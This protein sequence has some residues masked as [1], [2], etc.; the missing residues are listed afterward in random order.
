MAEELSR[1]LRSIACVF[2]PYLTLLPEGASSPPGGVLPAC[3]TPP[4]RPFHFPKPCPIHQ[5][6]QGE[7][8]PFN[9]LN[10]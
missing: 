7:P 5:G 9:H 1:L 3:S 4:T 10:S 2:K 8:A 6:L